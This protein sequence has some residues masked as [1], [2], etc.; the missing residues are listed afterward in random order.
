MALKEEPEGVETAKDLG[1]GLHAVDLDVASRDIDQ[2]DKEGIPI[3]V[4]QACGTEDICGDELTRT[5][6]V[7]M[8][9][10]TVWR[11]GGAALNARTAKLGVLEDHVHG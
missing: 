7:G 11:T 6:V 2:Q 4:R 10:S 8:V 3:A 5:K 1:G 9:L